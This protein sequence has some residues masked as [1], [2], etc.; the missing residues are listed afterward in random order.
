MPLRQ[1]LCF[2]L[3]IDEYIW[4]GNEQNVLELRENILQMKNN[5]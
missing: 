2:S 4:C 3:L 1:L 5:F